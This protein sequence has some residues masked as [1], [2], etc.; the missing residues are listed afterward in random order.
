MHRPKRILILQCARQA[1]PEYSSQRTICE[2]V[3]P[4][5]IEPFFVWQTH[6]KRPAADRSA[7]LSHP[8]QNLFLDFGRD[9]EVVSNPPRLGRAWMMARRFPTAMARLRRYIRLVKPDAVYTS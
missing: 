4:E 5:R 6:T 7:A 2:S 1:S 9:L 3:D 8:E